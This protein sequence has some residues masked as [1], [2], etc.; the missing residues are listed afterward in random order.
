MTATDAELLDD[1][2]DGRK[3]AELPERLLQLATVA[4]EL[5]GALAYPSLSR[6]ERQ[7]VLVRAQVLSR[8]HRRLLGVIPRPHRPNGPLVLAA[9]AGGA[10]VT[11]AFIG[12]ALLRRSGH[13]AAALPPAVRPA[14]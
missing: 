10:A 2:L 11:L 8:R 3:G 14:A 7:R 5:A 13:S 9:G 6:A 12:L 1:L 4:A